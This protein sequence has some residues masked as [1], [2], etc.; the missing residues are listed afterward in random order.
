MTAEEVDTLVAQARAGDRTAFRALVLALQ[1][2][3]RNF[4]A[5]FDVAE[6]LAEEVLQATF[7]T[8]YQ[9]LARYEPRR[10]FAAWLKAIARNHLLK[11]LRT[12]RRHAADAADT[13]AELAAEGA[14]DALEN[15]DEMERH[16]RRLKEC[17]ARLPEA[18]R[19]LIE[20]RYVAQRSTGEMASALR[21]S[22]VWVRV[23]LCRVRK[24]LRLCMEGGGVEA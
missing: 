8:A 7:V 24:A 23:N 11:E 22:E 14:L 16:T 1:H 5:T 6:G 12:R 3:L 21:R 15:A 20:D 13:L 2:D 19:R 10:A 4:L 9:K 17:L 18:Q